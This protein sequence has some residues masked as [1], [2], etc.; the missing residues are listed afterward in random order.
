MNK[1]NINWYPGHMAKT[2]RLIKEK[3]DIIDVIFEVID[4]R[5]P[6]SSKIKDIDNIIKDKPRIL[7]MTKIDLCDMT[8]TKKWIAYY[9]RFGYIVIGVDLA[10]NKNVNLI[11]DKSREILKELQ[12][13]KKL[14]GMMKKNLRA[15]IIGIPNVGKSTLINRLVGKKATNV[16]NRPGITKSLDWIRIGEFLELLD[17]PGILWPKF[18]ED[19]VALNLASM[20]AIKEEILPADDITIYILKIL[21]KYYP[22][23]LKKRYGIEYI[24]EDDIISVLDIIGKKRGAIIKGGDI[25]YKKVYNIVMRDLA[26]GSLG[27]VTFDRY[28]ED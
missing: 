26:D 23:A 19:K 13:K 15:L 5:I 11:I 20:T 12:E 22:E 14:K 7:I 2:K 4:A 28:K 6:Y 1:V 17:S 3:K 25:D 9:E 10:N 18:D 16:G 21:F 8:E 27:P 24:D